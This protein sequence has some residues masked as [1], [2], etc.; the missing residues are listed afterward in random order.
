MER[1]RERGRER[2]REGWRERE[3]GRERRERESG[4]REGFE[5]TPLSD[6]ECYLICVGGDSEGCDGYRGGEEEEE[7][8]DEEAA[9]CGMFS[10]IRM[11]HLP[12]GA[13]LVLENCQSISL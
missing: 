2:E 4:S 8:D 5:G 13:I 7:R 6:E 1:E 9:R 10:Q 3:R 12:P 11:C